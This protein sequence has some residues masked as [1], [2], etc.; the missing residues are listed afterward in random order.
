MNGPED[1][2]ALVLEAEGR[3]DLVASPMALDAARLLLT[4]VEGEAEELARRQ[5]EGN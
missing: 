3:T 1:F 5:S 4:R 2:E